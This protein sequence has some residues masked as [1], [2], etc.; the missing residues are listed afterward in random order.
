M[1]PAAMAS[2]VRSAMCRACAGVGARRGGP[3]A[4]TA[5]PGSAGGTS[6]P[7]RSRPIRG[8]SRRRAPRRP[9]PSRASGSRA[10]AADRPTSDGPVRRRHRDRPIRLH[11]PL[12]RRPPHPRAGSRPGE[13][14]AHGADERVG[15]REDLLPL[16]EPRLAERLHD[17]AE[18]GHAV[19]LDGREVRPGVEGAPV[20]RAEDRHGP[21]AR[22]G[23]GLGGRHVDGVEVGPLLPVDLDRDE[24]LGQVGRRRRVLEALVGHDVAPVARGVADG[25][26]DRLVLVTG[27]AQGLVPPGEP[28]HRVVGVLAE[29]RARLVGQVVH[30]SDARAPLP[31]RRTRRHT[32]GARARLGR[33][34]SNSGER[35]R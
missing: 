32:G 5:R 1:P 25:D 12:L 21:T 27:P 9:G 22:P 35:R 13:L 7:G 3:G 11:P 26:E 14:L 4:G 28:L 33:W 15:L 30:G 19:A 8:R 16:A 20:G 24:P 34:S 10:P 17:A 31:M 29:I 23:Q 2:S 6:A 18:R